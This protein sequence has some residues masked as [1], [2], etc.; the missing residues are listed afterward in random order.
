[1]RE[2]KLSRRRMKRNLP[3]WTRIR[4]G[5]VRPFYALY[6]PDDIAEINNVPSLL[7]LGRR[8]TPTLMRLCY[9]TDQEDYVLLMFRVIVARLKEFGVDCVTLFDEKLKNLLYTRGVHEL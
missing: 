7:K 3:E 2:K 8:Y 9:S 6:T 1:M 4:R 5:C